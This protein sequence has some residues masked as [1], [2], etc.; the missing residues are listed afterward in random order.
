MFCHFWKGRRLM[1]DIADRVESVIARVN[2]VTEKLD[3]LS[4]KVDALAAP[5]AP[6]V[7]FTAVLAAIADVKAQLLPTGDIPAD[8]STG[9]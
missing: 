3:A 8:G 9:A 1:S 7:D 5:A 2:N 6:T 4:K